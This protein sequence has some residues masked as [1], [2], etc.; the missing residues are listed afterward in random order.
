MQM[1]IV[2]I[3]DHPMSKPGT[4]YYN[5]LSEDFSV[6]A[7]PYLVTEEEI[8]E[9]GQRF[10]PRPFHTDADEAR[11][12]VFGGLVAPGCLIFSIR[13]WLV[14]QLDPCP[15]YLAGL[16]LDTMS[17]PNPARPGDHLYLEVGYLEGRPSNSHEGAGVVTFSN[18]M[19]NQNGETIMTMNAR[20]L[21]GGKP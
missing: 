18:L 3:Q 13:S 2:T 9:F 21:V 12:S 1:V 17:L 6:R 16:G 14:N 5:D 20:V 10:D 8:L 19:T 11:N 7:G 15:A 4:I